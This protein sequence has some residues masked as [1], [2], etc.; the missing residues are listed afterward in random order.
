LKGH[1]S[2]LFEAIRIMLEVDPAIQ[3]D[4]ERERT[5]RLQIHAHLQK[6]GVQVPETP[7]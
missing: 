6:M 5:K 2:S 4:E 1:K 7:E 3:A